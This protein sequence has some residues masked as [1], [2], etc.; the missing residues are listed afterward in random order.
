[1][2][3][4]ARTAADQETPST[5]EETADR[6]MPADTPKEEAQPAPQVEADAAIAA[7]AEATA[8]AHTGAAAETSPEVPADKPADMPAAAPTK[9]P[10]I[11]PA[12]APGKKIAETAFGVVDETG[13][14]WVI[15][16]D[17]TRE[18]GS[19]PEG[20]P[21]DPFALYV[22]RYLD[23]A[24]TLNL[25]EAR[26]PSLPAK[27]IDA[28][29][30]TLKEQL[31]EP[32][33][34]GDIPALRAQLERLIA[35]SKARKEELNAD[36]KRAREEALVART[37]VVE[38]A[39]EIAAQPA[40][41]T[42]WKQSGQRLRELLDEWRNLQRKGPRLD[43]SVEDK[44]WKRFSAARTTFDRGRRQFF[45]ALDQ[46]Q[47]EARA[48]KESLIAQA[49]A[50]QMS[51]DWRGTSAA[52]R[53]LMEKWKRAGRASRKEDDELWA[54]FRGAQQVFFD[55]RRAH[56]RAVDQEFGDNL[57]RKQELAAQAEALLPV[58]DIDATK[59]KLRSIQE[60]WEDVGPVPSREV[61]RIEGRLKAVER[62]LREAE[63]REW[64]RSNP[65]TKARATGMMAQLEDSI[66]DLEKQLA[67]A[68]SEGNEKRVKEVS[69]ALTTKQMWYQQISASMK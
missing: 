30:R 9:A 29:V 4:N 68:Q 5:T 8:E 11:V 52:Y 12:N 14:V 20:I 36:R 60:Q 67:E 63:N 25:F 48:E 24:A 41:R 17:V 62:E 57:A 38:Q 23:L 35:E 45:A 31:V 13:A 53:D 33:V 39:E 51:E 56:D 58:T 6:P 32:A 3:E 42:Q 15:D 59:G 2:T 7:S 10:A 55:N 27:D 22:R 1:M 34:V 16:G 28:T 64:R 37:R 44:L 47:K 65:E 43:K 46:R 49:E 40:D 26:L 18:V 61:S 66:A 50:L 21:E 19:Y 54:R 69:D